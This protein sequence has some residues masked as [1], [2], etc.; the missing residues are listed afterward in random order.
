MRYLKAVAIGVGCS[1]AIIAAYLLLRDEP[2]GPATT[3]TVAA[4]PAVARAAAGVGVAAA[5]AALAPPTS[6]RAAIAHEFRGSALPRALLERLV[7]GDVASVAR[8]LASAPDPAAAVE[9]FDLQELCGAQSEGVTS[10]LVAADGRAALEASGVSPANRATLATLLEEHRAWHGRFRPACAAT[11]FDTAS[12]RA[13]LQ[14]AGLK[15]DAAS[16]ER[17]AQLDPRPLVRL[18]SAALLGDPRAAFRVALAELPKHAR[19]GRSWLEVAAMDDPEAGAYFG[20]CLLAGCA[21]E[22]DPVA[23]RQALESAA[24]SGSLFALGVLASADSPDGARRWARNDELLVPVAPRDLDALGINSAA[25]YPWA[26]LAASLAAHGCFGFEFRITA[27]ALEART[28]FERSLR[29]GELA[30]AQAQAEELAA[31]TLAATRHSLSC[32]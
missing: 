19:D 23:A 27:E 5:P 9:L 24:R 11:L 32:D 3:P 13:R 21:G 6:V 2:A 28:R 10:E 17:L 18:Q 1:A 31:A 29:P 22:A 25:A 26:S 15:G 30:S 7:A 8:E 20:I 4:A 16:L 14:A 12:I